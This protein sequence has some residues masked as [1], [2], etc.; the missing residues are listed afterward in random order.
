MKRKT[1][2]VLAAAAM[3]A[4]LSAQ[5]VPVADD[6]HH[7]YRAVLVCVGTWG[8]NSGIRP[9]P[10]ATRD[11]EAL[12]DAYLANRYKVTVLLDGQATSEGIKRA[13]GEHDH[14]ET[15]VIHVSGHGGMVREAGV[16]K[17]VFIPSG[18]KED[19]IVRD[20]LPLETI[21]KT[22]LK[23]R[24]RRLLLSIDACRGNLID[25][26][27]PARRAALDTRFK[28]VMAA[29]PVTRDAAQRGE[30]LVRYL[31]ATQPGK[32]AFEVADGGVYSTAHAR[33]LKESATGR[34]IRMKS[35]AE[36]LRQEVQSWRGPS[37]ESQQ[38]F[39]AGD[40]NRDF[41]LGRPEERGDSTSPATPLPPPCAV[42]V[43]DVCNR[44]L[45]RGFPDGKDY[46]LDRVSASVLA[47]YDKD[48]KQQLSIMLPADKADPN[49]WQGRFRRG[50]DLV[51]ARLELDGG[52]SAKLIFIK[53]LPVPPVVRS[54]PSVSQPTPPVATNAG[55]RKAKKK[56]EAAPPQVPSPAPAPTPTPA[57]TLPKSVEEV[58]HLIPVKAMPEAARTSAASG[59]SS[60]ETK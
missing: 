10:N 28:P 39:E 43:P 25:P 36:A 49:R 48:C 14:L 2:L 54:E 31:F 55:D 59:V 7:G 13:I 29:P 50:D 56:P 4:L 20:A 9:L 27:Q 24:P 45:W 47:V 40:T 32:P 15:L 26:L 22:A 37:Q 5:Q 17:N 1:L 34:D 60:A 44:D 42:F 30:T 41:V 23:T 19:S 12:R 57:V 18:A 11:C 16:D 35:F 51:N 33:L 38:I 21:E 46:C 58:V 3:S 53:E 8:P 6:L 52:L